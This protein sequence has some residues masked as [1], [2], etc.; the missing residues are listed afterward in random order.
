LTRATRAGD[1]PPA[2]AESEG[3]RTCDGVGRGGN[4][5]IVAG[6]WFSG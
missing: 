1:W 6:G 2:L 3:C 5:D 4:P